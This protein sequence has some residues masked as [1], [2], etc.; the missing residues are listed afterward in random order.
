[1]KRVRVRRDHPYA[2]VWT[3]LM[4]LVALTI[5]LVTEGVAAPARQ[6]VSSPVEQ[7]T[8]ALPALSVN[9]VVLSRAGDEASARIEAARYVARGAAGYILPG[10]SE[11]L[12]VG[13]GY[14][15]AEEAAKV[16]KKLSEGEKI[17]ASVAV[18]EAPALSVRLTGTSAQVTAL[19]GAEA[20]LRHET[21]A[22]GEA[23]FKLDAGEIQLSGAREALLSARAEAKKAREALIK[24]VSG[25]ENKASQGL[26]ALLTSLEDAAATMLYNAQSSPLF[27]SSQMKYNYIDLRLRHIDFI[28]RLAAGEV[29]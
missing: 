27:F 29:S 15:S 12:I 25:E 17:A 4:L 21:N 20:S 7:V 28:N 23:A 13:A 16:M 8:W 2:P 3:L 19:M 6:A 11:Y 24:A 18:R 10:A 22:L 26:T 14:E 1:M 9:L 5:Y